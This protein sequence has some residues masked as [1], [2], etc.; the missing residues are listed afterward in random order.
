MPTMLYRTEQIRQWE[1]RWFAQGNTSFGLMQ[2]AAWA[3]AQWILAHHALASSACVVCGTGNNG[4]DGWLVAAYLHQAGWRVSVLTLGASQSDDSQQARQAAVSMGVKSQSFAGHLPTVDVVIDAIFGIGLNRAPVGIHAQAIETINRAKRTPKTAI[5]PLVIALDVPS[6]VQSDRGE[7]WQGYAVEADQTLCFLGLKTGLVTGEAK[8]YTGKTHILAVLPPDQTMTVFARY[9]TRPPVL[10]PRAVNSH[11]GTH[12]HVLLIG[13][14]DG[15]GGAVTMAAEAAVRAG[16]GK[17][18][19]LTQP[20]HLSALLARSPHVMSQ[21]L[22]AEMET[23]DR[24]E[25]LQALMPH[26]NSVAIGMGLGRG[27]WGRMVWQS[28]L[29]YLLDAQTLPTVL[30]DADAL[31]HLRD[32]DPTLYQRNNAHW[33]CTPHAGE[34]ARLLDCSPADVEADRYEAILQLQER[35]GGQWVLKGAGSLVLDAGGLAVCGLGNA[36]MAVGGMGDV[37]AGLG[38]GLLA[39]YPD[40]RLI[41]VVCLHAAAGDVAAQDGQRG[42]TALDVVACIRQVV[43]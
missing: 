39:Q 12:G 14:D 10:A 18:S 19:V 40:L 29:P 16:A 4:G 22:S 11:K 6:G 30:V 38:A 3:A 27:Y 5:K 9:H 34:A 1:Q 42:M 17:I 43:R 31:Y 36:G 32:T 8:N 26:I 13:G 37:L 33:H 2:Q 24:D 23:E 15:M 21:G 25:V 20:Q 7:V 41:D 35:Y 28:V